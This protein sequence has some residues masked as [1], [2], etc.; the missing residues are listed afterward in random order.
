MSD[1]S[2]SCLKCQRQR[3]PPG[4][5]SYDA[6]NQPANLE[7]RFV[8]H[9]GSLWGGRSGQADLDLCMRFHHTPNKQSGP[10][11]RDPAEIIRGDAVQ[12]PEHPSERTWR[13][14]K[15]MVNPGNSA[16]PSPSWLRPCLVDESHLSI[17]IFRTRGCQVRYL[18]G[19]QGCIIEASKQFGVL[20]TESLPRGEYRRLFKDI[21]I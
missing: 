17:F 16:G 13:P 21:C 20:R 4:Q 18:P 12:S 15:A 14:G 7:T 6:F 19:S 11:C 10:G 8:S 9:G 1:V 5:S 3:A 2:R